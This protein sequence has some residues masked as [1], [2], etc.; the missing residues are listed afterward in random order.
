VKAVRSF[1]GVNLS[2]EAVRE[3]T[4]ALAGLRVAC[5]EQGWDIKWV[6]PPNLQLVLTYLGDVTPTVASAMSDRLTPRARRVPHFPLS[7]GALRLDEERGD[8]LVIVEV[9]DPGG[10]LALVVESLARPL[11]DVGYGPAAVPHRNEII[12]GRVRKKPEETT[13]S[14]VL[15]GVDLSL[16]DIETSY[17]TESV[18]Y[19]CD[20]AVAGQE[21]T[22]MGRYRFSRRQIEL[23]DPPEPQSVEQEATESASEEPAAIVDD[24]GAEAEVDPATTTDAPQEDETTPESGEEEA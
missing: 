20:D 8:G 12:V 17:V 19:R 13:F 16:G 1:I 22:A 3:L 23:P 10:G 2:V 9:K 18:L 11:D 5:A 6:A 14:D 7:L 15:S 24:T 4:S 21:Y